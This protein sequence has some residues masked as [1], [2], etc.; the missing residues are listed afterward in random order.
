MQRR[1]IN[2]MSPD[3]IIAEVDRLHHDGYEQA[4]SWSLGQMCNHLSEGIDMTV[5]GT[6]RLIPRFIKRAFVAVF[7]VLLPLGKIGN[8]LGLRMPTSLP[9]KQPVDDTA[10][11]Q[12][13]KDNMKKLQSPDHA[14]LLPF[15]LFHCNHH[16]SFLIPAEKSAAE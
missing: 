7:M 9:Q 8:A 15:H 3:E 10:G 13:L 2:L 12:R 14:W 4:G 16:L 1:N 6:M 11:V 5:D